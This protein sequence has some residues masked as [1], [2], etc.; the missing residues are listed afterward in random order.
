VRVID[1]FSASL[2]NECTAP[3][4]RIRMETLDVLVSLARALRGR[5]PLRLRKE[6]FVRA[7]KTLPLALSALCMA[8]AAWGE[9]AQEGWALLLWCCP[10]GA[11][12]SVYAWGRFGGA[13]QAI[14]G[15]PFF[16][17]AGRF[18][19]DLFGIDPEG[20]WAEGPLAGAAGA[21]RVSRF[22]IGTL[23]GWE[24]DEEKRA[25]S[26][27]SAEVLGVTVTVINKP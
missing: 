16:A 27:E 7:F 5:G 23:L 3:T 14:L 21:S 10:F 6:D 2:I 25:S 8:A 22:V 24:L 26:A 15:R 17:P 11:V 13:V 1:D 12:A 19:G 4:E 9:A 18:V 20:G